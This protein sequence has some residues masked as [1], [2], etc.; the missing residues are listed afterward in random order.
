MTEL[1]HPTIYFLGLL[2]N[3]NIIFSSSGVQVLTLILLIK[4]NFLQ[5]TLLCIAI[6]GLYVQ[7]TVAVHKHIYGNLSATVYHPT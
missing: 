5:K 3:L 7:C 2:K 4:N 1:L 6:F